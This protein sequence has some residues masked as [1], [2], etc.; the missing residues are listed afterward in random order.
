MF[1]SLLGCP[2][3][4]VNELLTPIQVG[5]IRHHSFWGCV[6]CFVD[7]CGFPPLK[8]VS[9]TRGNLPA[10]GPESAWSETLGAPGIQAKV[11]RHPGFPWIE[12]SLNATDFGSF[13]YLSRMSFKY[14]LGE[15]LFFGMCLGSKYLFSQ[16]VWSLDFFFL[17]KKQG[18][19]MYGKF[20]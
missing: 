2:R 4:L 3:Y 1:N 8:T 9:E 12:G 7:L 6:P 18:M 11:L 13:N 10:A 19:D 16:G 20:E 17:G 15:V 14:L 5:W